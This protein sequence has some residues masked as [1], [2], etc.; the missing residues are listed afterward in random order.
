MPTK[1]T[2]T[3]KKTTP[4]PKKENAAKAE[5]VEKT[6][7]ESEVQKMIAAAVAEAMKEQKGTVLTVRDEK[8]TLLFMGGIAKGTIVPLGS[9]GKITR[10]GGMIEVS[11]K[12][13]LQGVDPV[14]DSMLEDRK[15]IVLNG[16]DEDERIRYDVDYKPGELLDVKAFK[17]I[18]DYEADE[19]AAIYKNLCDEHKTLVAKIFNTAYFEE[20]DNR[21]SLR[22]VQSLNALGAGFDRILRD[23]GANIGNIN[24]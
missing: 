1:K 16:L 11:K 7:S 23:M 19:I 4:A 3:V 12:D 24:G 13:F 9:L 18:L 20:H 15:L 10:D 21:V 6:F 22:K 14:V 8:V 5:K 2:E 17:R